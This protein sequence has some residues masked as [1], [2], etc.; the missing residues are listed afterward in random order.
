MSDKLKLCKHG[1]PIAPHITCGS[2]QRESGVEVGGPVKAPI[3]AGT[4]PK[5]DGCWNCGEFAVCKRNKD[6]PREPEDVCAGWRPVP[7]KEGPAYRKDCAEF[8]T[9]ARVELGSTC[10]NC[11]AYNKAEEVDP[12]TLAPCPYC[13]S[14][15]EKGERTLEIVHVSYGWWRVHCHTCGTNGPNAGCKS[16][17][18]QKWNHRPI[19]GLDRVLATLDYWIDIDICS[20]DSEHPTGSCLHCDMK[21]LK[22]LLVD[23]YGSGKELTDGSQ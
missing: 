6:Y 14:A 20:C 13:G 12:W 19:A 2:C 5:Q 11:K 1:V 3:P 17:A 8:N 7:V 4:G 22:E 15:F 18:L 9:C 10:E 21:Q 16:E 23:T